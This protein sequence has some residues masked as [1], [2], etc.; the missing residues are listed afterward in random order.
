MIDLKAFRKAKKIT[1]IQVS[2]DIEVDQARVSKYESGK[3][4]SQFITDKLIAYYEDIDSY[5]IQEAIKLKPEYNPINHNILHVPLEAEAGY[6]SSNDQIVTFDDL[7]QWNYPGLRGQCFSF[8]VKG[9]SM[10]PTLDQGDLI[11]ADRQPVRNFEEIRT[12]YLYAVAMTNGQI[13]VKRVNRSNAADVIWL[14]SDNQEYEEVEVKYREDFVRLHKV[15]R[16]GK[17]NLSH[18]L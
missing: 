10:E 3:D 5:M 8:F 6:I 18:R 11:I 16:F 4:P 2:K 9:D 15:R 12:D 13:L 14:V 17:W 1:Q 7:I